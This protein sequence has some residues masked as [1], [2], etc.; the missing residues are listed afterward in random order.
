[1][2][3]TMAPI[4]GTPRLAA[5]LSIAFILLAGCSKPE[6]ELGLVSGVVT[7][8]GRPLSRANVVFQPDGGVGTTSV[9]FTNDSGEYQLTFSRTAKGAIV[10][11]HEVVINVWPTDENPK[12]IKVPARYNTATELKAEVKPGKNSYDFQLTSEKSGQRKS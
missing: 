7:Y 1:M 11:G 6:F 4:V 9:G 2:S 12:P 10:G 3:L 8:D 5:A